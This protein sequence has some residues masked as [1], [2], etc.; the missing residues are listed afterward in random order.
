M[1]TWYNDKW[2]RYGTYL[3]NENNFNNKYFKLTVK[4]QIHDEIFSCNFGLMIQTFHE[5]LVGDNI[6]MLCFSV[7]CLSRVFPQ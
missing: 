2:K 7:S 3:L 1:F 6:S 5:Q 4:V